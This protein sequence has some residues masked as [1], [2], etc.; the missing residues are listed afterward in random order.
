M[1][2]TSNVDQREINQFSEQASNWW[3]LEGPYKA[4]HAINPVRLE[5]IQSAATIAGKQC[6]DIGCGGGLL[7]EGLAKQHGR[8][9]AIDM[10]PIAIITAE[11]HAASESLTITYLVCT[12]EA[13]SSTHPAQFDIVTCLEM[14]EHVPDP[15]SIIQACATL[16]K[17]DGD[18]FFSTLNR[19]PWAYLGAILAAEYVFQWV[20]KG[21]HQY[22][23]FI[24]PSE[25]NT[26][27]SKAGLSLIKQQGLQ[28]N[29]FT[30]QTSLTQSMSINYITHYR[31]EAS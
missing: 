29:P 13:L 4:L 27:A 22:Q 2:N 19:H 9:A 8:V 17:P 1:K 15:E 23:R 18:I 6:L 21:T 3:N 10:D 30:Q 31:K 5:F 25:L 24:K 28:Y 12:A 11:Q 7:A 16:C 20:P 26:W 14:L